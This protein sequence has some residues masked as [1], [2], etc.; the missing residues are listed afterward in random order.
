MY[1]VVVVVVVVVVVEILDDAEARKEL[2]NVVAM[3]KQFPGLVA[4]H[5]VRVGDNRG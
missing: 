3:V 1:A 5:W 4:G 2:E